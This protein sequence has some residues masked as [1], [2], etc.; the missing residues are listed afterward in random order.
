MPLEQAIHP[1]HAGKLARSES[2]LHQQDDIDAVLPDEAPNETV[3]QRIVMNIPEKERSQE[4]LPPPLRLPELH[5]ARELRTFQPLLNFREFRRWH[6]DA[7]GGL[8]RQM[9]PFCHWTNSRSNS[10]NV[11]PLVSGRRRKRKRNPAPQIPA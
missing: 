3:G 10:S 9:F 5:F 6:A 8:S 11:R 1:Q 4:F 7:A 2:V